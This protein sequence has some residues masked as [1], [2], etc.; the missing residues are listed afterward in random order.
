MNKDYLLNTIFSDL[1]ENYFQNI[2]LEN[3]SFEIFFAAG[4]Y[5]RNKYL[6]GNDINIKY[7]YEYYG[8]CHPDD[9]SVC[10]IRDFEFLISK[11]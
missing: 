11:F 2:F 6:W 10:I 4:N 9:I 5:I 7:F 3:D 8:V 1:K